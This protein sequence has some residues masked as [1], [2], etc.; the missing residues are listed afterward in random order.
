[1]RS[2]VGALAVLVFASPVFA[3]ANTPAKQAAP[4]GPAAGAPAGSS[5][6]Q[7]HALGVAASQSIR[8]L[9][10]G[11]GEID[12]VKRGFAEGLSGNVKRDASDHE[13]LD[14]F[15]RQRLAAAAAV[16]KEAGKAFAAKAAAEKGAQK[17]ASGAIYR[18]L[19]EGAGAT[20]KP[21]DTVKV[22]ITGTLADGTAFDRDD[23]VDELLMNRVMP[24]LSEG[25]A[26]MKPGGKA[27]LVCPS[28]TAYGDQ[29]RAPAVPPGATLVLEVGLISAAAAPPLRMP[30]GHGGMPPGHPPMGGGK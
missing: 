30:P 22:T 20:P 12:V 5:D 29:G 19:K 13:K 6:A 26:R 10:L 24:C 14:A 11:P 4:A 16:N 17:T 18:S 23:G 7:L 28:D 9:Q 2:F 21:T 27:R 25:I 1:M 3:L 8:M 15:V